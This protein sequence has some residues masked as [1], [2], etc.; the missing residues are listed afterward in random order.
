MDDVN[1]ISIN[2]ENIQD[3]QKFADR[4]KQSIDA[5]V[6]IIDKDGRVLA[7]SDAD[8]TRME[9]HLNRDEILEAGLKGTGSSV[10]R[11]KT[12]NK[13][14]IYVAKKIKLKERVFYIRV[15][16]DL[17]YINELFLSFLFKMSAILV[18][19]ISAFMFLV[20]KTSQDISGET[21]KI[22]RFLEDLKHQTKPFK[23]HSDFSKE[24]NDITKLLSEV[25]FELADK[26]RKKAKY[27]ARLKLAN[28]QKDEIISAISHEFKNPISVIK[29]YSQT[30]L[31]DEHINEKIKLKFLQKVHDSANRLTNMIDRLRL[32]VKLEG[33]NFV[34]DKNDVD[35]CKVAQIIKQDI[36]QT[37]PIRGI[38]IICNENA[39]VKADETLLMI[40]IKNLVENGLKYSE[41][42]VDLEIYHDKIVIKDRGIGIKEDEVENITQKFYRVSKNRWNNSLGLGL[43]IVAN[44]LK[45][46][47]FKLDIKSSYGEGSE[48]TIVF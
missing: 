46:H 47:D 42:D 12:L 13:D 9:N 45:F 29:G 8:Y 14:L 10:R 48:F 34:L 1:L 7:D 33:E 43:A 30:I 15:A 36:L 17:D 4:I 16:D 24:F 23:I 3:F 37:Y 6:T 31:E 35:L 20:Y 44:I 40:A 28:K 19:F 39:V 38:N 22:L 25:S 41:D 26:N 11:S 21:K 2:V 18:V 32:A 27:T 5:R